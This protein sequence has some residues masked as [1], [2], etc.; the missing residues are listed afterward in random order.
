MHQ[1]IISLIV[2]VYNVECYLNRCLLSLSGLNLEYEIIIVNDGSTDSSLAVAEAFQQRFSDKMV[3]IVSQTNQGLSQAR[4][5][6]LSLAKG[7]YVA[8]I[9]SDD[10]VD[11]VNFSM[12][13][14]QAVADS[15][16]IAI[17]KFTYFGAGEQQ[18]Q[19]TMHEAFFQRNVV[20]GIEAFDFLRVEVWIKVF[21]RAFLIDN[22]ISFIPGLLFEDE[23]F[24][25]H[26]MLLAQRIRYF[27][28][29]FYFYFQRESSITKS[30]AKIVRYQHYY[31]IALE[32]FAL[33]DLVDKQATKS[34][35]CRRAWLYLLESL[36]HIYQHDVQEFE[37]KRRQ[38]TELLV[39]LSSI[40]ELSAEDKRIIALLLSQQ[41]LLF[42]SRKE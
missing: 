22:A 32:I 38:A 16:D 8:F 17:G 25:I 15:L 33:R 18:G 19:G 35:V 10:F 31:R 14:Q 39:A 34:L 40:E 29:P 21:R 26:T 30:T 28:L 37:I 6:G 3:R 24:H 11:P 13:I 20:A 23:V 2:P 7:Q 4:N 36:P 12:F 9:D 42:T 5:L 27:D 1:P 41:A